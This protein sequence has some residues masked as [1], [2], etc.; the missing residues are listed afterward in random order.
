MSP[1]ISSHYSPRQYRA[2]LRRERGLV[3][4]AGFI[5]RGQLVGWPRRIAK[6]ADLRDCAAIAYA[7]LQGETPRGGTA[8][9]LGPP[10]HFRRRQH[11]VH[12]EMERSA[13]I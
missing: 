5:R 8:G 9:E 6:D 10:T 7:T 11:Q 4:S 3:G 13:A 1:Q 2:V 12:P